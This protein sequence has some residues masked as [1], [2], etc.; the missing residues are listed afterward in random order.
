[1]V[2]D[3]VELL[4]SVDA[5]S[6]E[7][8]TFRAEDA[9]YDFGDDGEEFYAQ[10]ICFDPLSNLLEL[11]QDGAQTIVSTQGTPVEPEVFASPLPVRP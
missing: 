2:A 1:M 5:A 6:L 7:T 11:H 4:A 8:P 3:R 9:T 10:R